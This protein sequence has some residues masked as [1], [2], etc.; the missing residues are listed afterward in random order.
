MNV[1]QPIPF[2]LTDRGRAEVRDW[3][4]TYNAPNTCRHPHRGYDKVDQVVYCDDCG[5]VE[6]VLWEG[7]QIVDRKR[8]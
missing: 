6:Q 4:A 5:E 8:A 7:G 1:D 3:V 2:V